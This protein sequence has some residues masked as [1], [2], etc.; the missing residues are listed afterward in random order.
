MPQMRGVKGD[1]VVIY[2]E[3]LT[4][5]QMRYHRFS[6]RAKNMAVFPRSLDIIHGAFRSGY[7]QG[8]K[9]KQLLILITICN[10]FYP[11]L[12]TTLSA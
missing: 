7:S 9:E 6:P 12:G 4:K 11:T 10:V 3:P 2:R 5:Q 8:R 1:A